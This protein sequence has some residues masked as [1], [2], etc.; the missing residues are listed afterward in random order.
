M[1]TRQDRKLLTSVYRKKTFTG[2]YMHWASFSPTQRKVNL[3]H[4]LT[5]RALSIC[6]PCQLESELKTVKSILLQNGYPEDVVDYNISKRVAIFQSP[7]RQGPRP[8]PIY[9]TLPWIGNR[10]VQFQRQL[11]KSIK[12]CFG[13]VSL[14]LH[15]STTPLAKFN[16][17]DPLPALL[18]S[19]V[20]YEYTCLCEKRYIGR[21]D[22]RLKDRIEQHVPA[23]IRKGNITNLPDPNKQSSAIGKHLCEELKCAEA[24]DRTRFR[25]L[26]RART[27]FHMCILE[28]AYISST[29]PILCRQKSFVYT[30]IV[31]NEVWFN[32]Y[33]CDFWYADKIGCV[34]VLRAVLE[35]YYK[36]VSWCSIFST[37][38]SI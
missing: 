5:L 11:E 1:V 35:N 7:R 31:F 20:I 36:P 19:N 4:T 33:L 13:P 28:A 2:Q 38:Q 29:K 17:K 6:S 18:Q 21:T 25:V 16:L 9:M 10:S 27:S 12:S 14:R 23:R 34:I 22:Q 8:C 26:A 24:Y 32:C 37:R 3:V 15:Y 30:L